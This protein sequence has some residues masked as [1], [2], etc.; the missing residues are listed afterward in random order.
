MNFY[1]PH[2]T[3]TNLKNPVFAGVFG[4]KTMPC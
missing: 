4:P 3:P 2:T 1:Y